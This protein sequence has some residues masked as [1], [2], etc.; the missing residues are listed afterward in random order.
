MSKACAGFLIIVLFSI[1]VWSS[2]T[3]IT[4]LADMNYLE[5]D[6]NIFF[7]PSLISRY[8]N[9]LFFELGDYSYGYME[10]QFAGILAQVR[11]VHLGAVLK[12][13]NQYE[14]AVFGSAIGADD[15]PQNPIQLFFGCSLNGVGLGASAYY[16][17]F[18][19]QDNMNQ[20]IDSLL[21]SRSTYDTTA[22]STLGIQ[23][24]MNYQLGDKRFDAWT[25]IYRHAWKQIQDESSVTALQYNSAYYSTE[26][27]YLSGA[28]SLPIGVRAVLPVSDGVTL[29]TGAA[30]SLTSLNVNSYDS[31]W[32]S[33]NNMTSA[34]TAFST[35]DRYTLQSA[36]AFGIMSMRYGQDKG[37]VYAGLQLGLSNTNLEKVPPAGQERS[38]K[39]TETSETYYYLP[40]LQFGLEHNFYKW[41]QFRAG[42]QY[43]RLSIDE[44]VTSFG[45]DYFST[46]SYTA[47]PGSFISLGSRFE[48]GRFSMD[49]YI[50]ESLLFEGL[51][52]ITGRE[53]ADP[54]FGKISIHYSFGRKMS[55]VESAPP[56]I[57]TPIQSNEN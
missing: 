53:S 21:Y 56:K 14:Q 3:R 31:G 54:L 43:S 42:M 52:I 12:R 18:E 32:S 33:Y 36:N 49:A 15:V 26:Q 55:E 45:Y 41:W 29:T 13:P 46:T 7:N 30:Y 16:A 22:S 5:D 35:L 27:N 25:G 44:E 10:N 19:H 23:L 17:N 9:E 40:I 20:N 51:N 48:F 24:G 39:F 11:H 8:S 2:E 37:T 34:D 47:S 50:S 57:E 4:T 38:S 1:S 6:N 28:F